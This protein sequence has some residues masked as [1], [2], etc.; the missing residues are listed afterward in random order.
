MIKLVV[1]DWNGTILADTAV[2][3]AAINFGEM[4]I[5]N[6]PPISVANYQ[7]IYDIPLHHYYQALGVSN[8]DH[9][10]HAAALSEGFHNHYEQLVG[11][12]RTRP[13][14]RHALDVLHA[15]NIQRIILSNH[16]TDRITEQLERL[17]LAHHFEYILANEHSGLVHRTGK[18][19]RLEKYLEE[20]NIPATD[21]VIV[22]DS[23]EEIRIAHALGAKVI[24]ITG[25]TCSRKRLQKAK[26]DRII[27]SLFQ[28]SKA[29]E[30]LA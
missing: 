5:L 19:H 16:I 12:T 1:F 2:V 24:S 13:G 7:T 11:K 20:H 10:K 26:P 9:E 28:L 8:K 29:M 21:V 25:G 17:K 23:L 14:A 15:K 18:Q 3:V 4:P 27:S 22:G 30:E 6:H